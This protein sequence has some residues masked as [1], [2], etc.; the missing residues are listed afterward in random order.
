MTT[1]HMNKH[2]FFFGTMTQRTKTALERWWQQWGFMSTHWTHW[3]YVGKVIT[4]FKSSLKQ[5]GLPNFTFSLTIPD[6]LFFKQLAKQQMKIIFNGI[7]TSPCNWLFSFYGSSKKKNS[8][9]FFLFFHSK[10][11]LE[12][13][14]FTYKKINK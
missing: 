8:F 6:W 14:K 1:I 3:K 12:V 7:Y 9:F 5:L 2:F 4:Y 10:V 13:I 11:R